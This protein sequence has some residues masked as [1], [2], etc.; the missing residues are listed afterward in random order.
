MT[1]C[2]G[3]QLQRRSQRPQRRSRAREDQLRAIGPLGIVG[4]LAASLLVQAAAV[5][6]GALIGL[7]LL[8]I[9]LVMIGIA[10]LTVVASRRTVGSLLA[11]AGIRVAQ[12]YG[13]GEQIR[14][15]VPAL[16][17]VEDAEIVRVGA[18]NTTLLTERGVVVVPNAQ[19]LRGA[20]DSS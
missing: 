12:P 7:P 14:V 11:G 16:N 1:A 19:M 3:D 15:F 13:P 6:G 4:P 17:S 2:R 18:A 10:V 8:A 5:V 9:V 20:N